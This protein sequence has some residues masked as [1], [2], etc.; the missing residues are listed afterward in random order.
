MNSQNLVIR[1]FSTIFLILVVLV[2]N[3]QLENLLYITTIGIGFFLFGYVE[4]LLEEKNFTNTK[5]E[6]KNL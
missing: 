1:G 2:V 4:R 3:S 5:K 6:V